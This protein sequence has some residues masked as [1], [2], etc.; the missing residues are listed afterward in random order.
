VKENHLIWPFPLSNFRHNLSYCH[1]W[2]L[3]KVSSHKYVFSSRTTTGFVNDQSLHTVYRSVA[4]VQ[5][6]SHHQ[7]KCVWARQWQLQPGTSQIQSKLQHYVQ[8]TARAPNRWPSWPRVLHC[9]RFFSKIIFTQLTSM[10]YL[11]WSQGQTICLLLP[12]H[13]W[14]KAVSITSSTV[15]FCCTI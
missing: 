13:N 12:L 8:S 3:W 7:R 14:L 15:A 4:T 1:N 10:Q 5:D 9:P 2:G 6:A 11:L